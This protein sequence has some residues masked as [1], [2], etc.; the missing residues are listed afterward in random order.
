MSYQKCQ[1]KKTVLF[2]I[3]LLLLQLPAALAF[4]H[5]GYM[6]TQSIEIQNVK[7]RRVS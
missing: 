2:I 1:E 6:A 3:T 5:V 4:I 7:A